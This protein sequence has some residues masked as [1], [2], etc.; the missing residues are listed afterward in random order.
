MADCAG[1]YAVLGN[2]PEQLGSA[3]APA[4]Q[5]FQ[6]AS[7]ANRA[8]VE[9]FLHSGGV[10]LL[11]IPEG[12]VPLFDVFD[13]SVL[14][15]ALPA[16]ARHARYASWRHCTTSTIDLAIHL[17]NA[18]WNASSPACDAHELA[19]QRAIWTPR[20][21]HVARARCAPGRMSAAAFRALL[22]DNTARTIMVYP[23]RGML[24]G[25]KPDN[26]M[27][28]E[29][30]DKPDARDLRALHVPPVSALPL[31]IGAP[32]L[33]R[34]RAHTLRGAPHGCD[35]ARD[36]VLVQVRGEKVLQHLGTPATERCLP[37][38]VRRAFDRA[39]AQRRH[40]GGDAGSPPCTLFAT[41]LADDGSISVRTHWLNQSASNQLA[42]RAARAVHAHVM[43]PGETP[44]L[45]ALGVLAL[46]G[47]GW[48]DVIV[49]IGTGSFSG[50]IRTLA[51]NGPASETTAQRERS[52][53]KTPVLLTQD[54]YDA[55]EC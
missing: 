53:G 15:A 14:T 8:F 31:M 55:A 47:S 29:L 27:R 50:W 9:P 54:Q 19:T 41:D 6:L 40:G 18:F 11:A 12:G 16:G 42:M 38:L 46:V 26:R 5:F 28:S 43:P 45:G 33:S 25:H 10:S 3:R 1:R 37:G 4:L 39:M 51:T 23:W 17:S 24:K 44:A 20:G 49:S 30:I 2:V 35:G 32:T 7:V 22:L 13:A 36:R 21:V 52:E 48:P 34:A